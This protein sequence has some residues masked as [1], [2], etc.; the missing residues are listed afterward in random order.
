MTLFRIQCSWPLPGMTASLALGLAAMA[1][2]Y[3]RVTVA[4]I[5]A[6]RPNIL[7]IVADDIG[8]GDVGFQGCQDIPTPHIDGIAAGGVQFTN[9]Y[10][11]A[12]VCSPSRAGLLIGRYQQRF[13]H[14][15]NPGPAK[16]TDLAEGGLP[17][18]ESTIADALKATGY[19]TAAIG[20]WHLGTSKPFWPLRRGFDEYYGFLG[21]NHPYRPATDVAPIFR[22]NKEVAAPAHLTQAFGAEAAAFIKRQTDKPFFLYLAFSAAHTPLQPDK[23]HLARFKA[24]AAPRRRAYAALISGMDD[25]IG[26][27]L[28]ALRAAG[29]ESNTLVIF[30]SDNGGP[31]AANGSSNAP[32]RGDKLT[33][34]EGGIRT[35][36]A[37][38]WKGKILAGG[39]YHQPVISL[40]AAATAAA[41]AGAKLGGP[42]RPIDGVDLLPYLQGQTKEPPHHT[43]YWR[44]GT[45]HA[46]RQGDYKLLQFAQGQSQLYDLRAD[47]SERNDLASAHPDIVTRLVAAYDAWN[48]ELIDPLW[49]RG[50]LTGKLRPAAAE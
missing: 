46:V 27:A 23:K 11:T 25:A 3:A 35:P 4:E 47:V 21:A 6:P 2:F 32:L 50:K 7:L 37:I 26:E 19:T 24:I 48:S 40:D 13:G 12:P 33:L 45:Q 5:V 29:K 18:S 41:A 8:Y 1:V 44:F 38:Q 14:E 39:T 15:F 9:G 16:P 10:V 20:K 43:L 28:E 42:E 36:F 17:L 49:K 34:W 22:D 31:Q 30:F